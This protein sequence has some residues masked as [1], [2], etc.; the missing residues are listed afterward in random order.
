M[1]LNFKTA[2]QLQACL[3]Q[4]DVDA[5]AYDVTDVCIMRQA[6]VRKRK[7]IERELGQ[8]V[9]GMTS[10]I[11]TAGVPCFSIVCV[12]EDFNDPMVV[13]EVP[14]YAAAAK[15]SSSDRSSRSGQRN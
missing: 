8:T 15:V 12:L 10:A 6:C 9:E 4:N 14:G 13:I 2:V 7:R 5:A 3:D 11:V 1:A